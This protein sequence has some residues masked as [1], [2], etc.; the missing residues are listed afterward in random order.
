[1]KIRDKPR[2]ELSLFGARFELLRTVSVIVKCA[3][4]REVM[5]TTD[6]TCY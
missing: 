6:G 1:M 5:R 2:T 4:I 3:E